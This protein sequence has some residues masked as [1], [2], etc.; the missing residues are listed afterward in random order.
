MLA[1]IGLNQPMSDT[2][3]GNYRPIDDAKRCH[4]GEP[5]I[6]RDLIAGDFHATSRSSR[7]TVLPRVPRMS[8]LASIMLK[9]G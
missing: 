1:W 4:N 2:D 7:L 8:R 5:A 9:I 3:G 6:E